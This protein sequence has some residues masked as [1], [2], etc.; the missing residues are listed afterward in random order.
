[1]SF[2]VRTTVFSRTFSQQLPG[3]YCARTPELAGGVDLLGCSAHGSQPPS[4]DLVAGPFR[5]RCE[6]ALSELPGRSGGT[7]SAE[8][9]GPALHPVASAAAEVPTEGSINGCSLDAALDHHTW[10]DYVWDE[11][12]HEWVEIPPPPKYKVVYRRMKGGSRF[13]PVKVKNSGTGG[14]S[15]AK[16][17]PQPPEPK[18]PSPKPQDTARQKGKG[19]FKPSK[20]SEPVE[21]SD[22]GKA[23]R[24]TEKAE[25]SKPDRKKGRKP[26]EDEEESVASSEGEKKVVK[27]A[28]FD[29]LPKTDYP[30]F[31]A[32]DFPNSRHVFNQEE[33]IDMF[34]YD[35]E[36][37]P[38]CGPTC[39]DLASG[40]KPDLAKYEMMAYGEDPIDALGTDLYLRGYAASRGYNLAIY[41]IKPDFSDFELVHRYVNSP[42]QKEIRLLHH[43]NECG[44]H[45][46]LL[47]ASLSSSHNFTFPLW[48]PKWEWFGWQEECT[49]SRTLLQTNDVDVRSVSHRREKLSYQD[50]Y[51]EVK[52]WS[53]YRV[54]GITVWDSHRAWSVFGYPVWPGRPTRDYMVSE[55]LTNVGYTELQAAVALGHETEKALLAVTRQREVNTDVVRGSTLTGTL[56]YLRKLGV[57]LTE[58]LRGV[59]VRPLDYTGLVTYEVPGRNAVVKGVDIIRANQEVPEF[60]GGNKV[61]SYS[62]RDDK[63]DRQPVAVAPIGTIETDRGPIMA[64]NYPSSSSESLLAAF[65]GRSM[66]KEPRRKRPEQ[67]LAFSKKL[68][69]TVIHKTN[70]SDLTEPDRLE[71]FASHYKEKRGKSWIDKILSDYEDWEKGIGP[72]DFADHSAFVKFE[73]SSKQDPL[74]KDWL[75]KPRLIM[76]MSNEMLVK[77]CTVLELIHRFND[78][79]FSKFQVKGLTPDEMAEKISGFC[80]TDHA[81]TDYASFESSIDKYIMEIEAHALILMAQLA[82][83][84]VLER[85]LRKFLNKPRRLRTRHGLFQIW[86]RCSGDFWTSFGNGIVNVCVQAF[87]KWV[88]LGRSD[89]D[90]LDFDWEKFVDEFCMLAEGDD[91]L[92]PQSLLNPQLVNE[93]GFDFSTSQLGVMPGDT[94]FL[95]S[96]WAGGKRYLNVAK[97][98]TRMLW[99]KNGS[100][101]RRSKQLYILRCM[102]ASVYHL[103]PGHP[104]LTAA[105]NRIG[106]LTSGISAFKGARAYLDRWKFPILGSSFPHDIQVDESMRGVLTEEA[107]GFTPLSVTAQ[108]ELERRLSEDEFL[109]VGSFFQ[110]DASVDSCVGILTMTD[111]YVDRSPAF[112]ALIRAVQSDPDVVVSDHRQGPPLREG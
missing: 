97:V 27:R 101:L 7:A 52:S 104:V 12:R 49:I 26:R 96:R 109:F 95:G 5:L 80:E 59:M 44:G 42:E 103:S 84:T 18:K 82:G 9:E 110:G 85:E 38:F 57:Q 46:T 91:G 58:Q 40:I 55:V 53:V 83:F 99:V 88:S 48:T 112:E 8:L 90:A 76:T 61:L 111:E 29:K 87:V 68:V 4:G 62:I 86:T 33:E 93:L 50:G 67:F 75:T 3:K 73:D 17:G 13:I 105:I 51:R 107:E 41:R 89:F 14:K 37:A 1:M 20:K 11:E 98:L 15:K 79:P 10:R 30:A 94:D 24:N 74:T 70:F 16:T 72:R 77:C 100:K 65:A 54:F 28:G 69:E 6:G 106:K 60:E 32:A 31:V 43:D 35:C 21:P 47:C 39:I 81:V 45:W 71:Y 108:L 2:R 25:K 36:G 92:M 64:G 22:S 78:G 56:W 102:A 23:T 19:N 63:P 34:S 66:N